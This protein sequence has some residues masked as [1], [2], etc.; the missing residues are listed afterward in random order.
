MDI[1]TMCREIISNKVA[2]FWQENL[3]IR[4]YHIIISCLQQHVIPIY[5]F[6]QALVQRGRLTSIVWDGG[7]SVEQVVDAVATIRTYNRKA[8][9]VCMFLDDSTNI[10]VLHSWFHWKPKNISNEHK[11]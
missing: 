11:N 2:E 3:K 5:E 9:G 1:L 7:C 8:L 4:K 10:P 6:K